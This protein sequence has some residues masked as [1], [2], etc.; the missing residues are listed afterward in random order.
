MENREELIKFISEAAELDPN[1]VAN[2]SDEVLEDMADCINELA[3]LINVLEQGQTTPVPEAAQNPAQIPGLA[4]T[5]NL[6]SFE[7]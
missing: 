4:E 5:E 1:L 7:A 2:G 3:E 6:Y